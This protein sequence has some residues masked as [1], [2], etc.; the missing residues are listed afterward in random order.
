MI[1]SAATPARS[2]G[3][4][5]AGRVLALTTLQQAGLTTIRFGLP[6]LAPFWRDA[7]GISLVQVGILLGAFDFGALLLF[8]PLGLLAD[9]WGEPA[10]LTVG[11]LFTAAMAAVVAEAH[12]FGALALLLALAGLGYGS[13][14]TA[15]TKAV[16]A[17]FGSRGRGIAMGIRQ[18]GL[19]IGGMIAAVLVPALAGAYGWRAGILGAAGVCALTGLLCA[20]G[21]RD[22]GDAAVD[23]DAGSDRRPLGAHLRGILA[24]AGIRRTTIVA[25]LLVIGQFCYQGYLA[26]YMVDH[27]GWS[28]HLAA[29]LLLAV[30]GGGVAGRLGWGVLSDRFLGGRRT[31][32]LAWCAAL[33]VVFPLALIALPRPVSVA[34]AAVVACAGGLLLLGWNG[35]YSTLIME[36]AGPRD[37]GAAMGVSMTMLYAV[38]FI[39]PPA[40]GWMIERTS[41]AAAWISLGVLLAVGYAVSRRIPEP[42]RATTGA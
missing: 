31:P 19:P 13:G 39:T 9:R 38:T 17:A 4:L 25:M 30:H 11:A 12:G 8:L 35:L 36:E 7:L 15:G 3:S 16:A 10:V 33:C 14:Q 20:V 40:F 28:K 26:L 34:T 21:L 1:P 2:A 41:Y 18:S 32:A 5:R 24:D 27:F 29:T 42:E 37:A 6:V 22:V 23:A